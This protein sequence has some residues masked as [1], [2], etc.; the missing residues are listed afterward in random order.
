MKNE[1]RGGNV[2]KGGGGYANQIN[3][4]GKGGMSEGSGLGRSRDKKVWGSAKKV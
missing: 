2:Q 3:K 4:A 1:R